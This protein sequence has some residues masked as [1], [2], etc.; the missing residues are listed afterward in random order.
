MTKSVRI[1]NADS[2][3]GHQLEVQLWEMSSTGPIL[4]SRHSLGSPTDMTKLVIHSTR[5]IV[6]KEDGGLPD[7]AVV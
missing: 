6:V 7:N 3:V 5:W 2:G 4:V 1:E